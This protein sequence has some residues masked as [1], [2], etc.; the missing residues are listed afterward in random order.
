MRVSDITSAQAEL[1][2]RSRPLADS[3]R[4]TYRWFDEQ[5]MLGENG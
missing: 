4:G 5:G 1:G 2:F 3:V